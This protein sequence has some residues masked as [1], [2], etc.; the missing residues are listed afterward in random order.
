MA[1]IKLAR[2][3][4]VGFSTA[5]TVLSA[6]REIIGAFVDLRWY[7][8]THPSAPEWV[9]TI[10]AMADAITEVTGEAKADIIARLDDRIER[11]FR[12]QVKASEKHWNALRASQPH[13]DAIMS[14]AEAVDEPR[15]NY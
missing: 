15:R 1:T 12:N 14:A 8:P 3:V 13:L 6:E 7:D 2:T 11:S 9:A 4:T 5:R 10:D